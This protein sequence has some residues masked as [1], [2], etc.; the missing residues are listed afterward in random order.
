MVVER[1]ID[2]DIYTDVIQASRAAYRRVAELVAPRLTANLVAAAG[3]TISEDEWEA[4]LADVS[5]AYGDAYLDAVVAGGIAL[6]VLPPDDDLLVLLESQSESVSDLAGIIRSLLDVFLENAVIEGLPADEIRERLLS[7]PSSPLNPRKADAFAR[8]AANTAVNAGFAAAFKAAGVPAISWITQRDDRV[9]DAHV[10]VDRDVIPNGDRFM[11]DGHEARYPGD[12]ALPIGLRINCRCMLGWVDGDQVKRAVDARRADLY[13]M[14]RQLNIRGRSKMRKAQLQL[15]VIETLCLQG[16]ASGTDCPD[17]FDDMNMATLL[18]HARL[19]RIRGRY[20]MR[21]HQLLDAVKDAFTTSD[22][23]AWFQFAT[24]LDDSPVAQ[25]TALA[26]LVVDGEPVSVDVEHTADLIE[27]FSRS[28]DPVDLTLVHATPF[29]FAAVADNPLARDEM[30]QI[31]EDHLDRFTSYLADHGVAWIDVD[32]DPLEVY[33][34][35]NELDGRKVGKMI[36]AIRNGQFTPEHPAFV[37]EEGRILDGHHRWAAQAALALSGVEQTMATR[38]VNVDT[39]TLLR[40]A[41]DYAELHDIESKSHGMAAAIATFSWDPNQPRHPRGSSSGGRW[42]PYDG[43]GRP[44]RSFRPGER[45]GLYDPADIRRWH[46]ERDRI[47]S[48]QRGH[49]VVAAPTS[50]QIERYTDLHGQGLD[51]LFAEGSSPTAVIP[52]ASARRGE[53]LYDRAVVAE[54]LAR[55]VRLSAFDPR[56]LHATQ[57]GVTK[58]GVDYYMGDRYAATGRTYADQNAAGNRYPVIYRQ[59]RTGELLILS[60]HHRATAALLD[61][62]NVHGIYIDPRIRVIP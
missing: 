31:P 49:A 24:A 52:F 30:P 35:Q 17:T 11:V 51:A 42:R 8:T 46:E 28:I 13:N 21:R 6:G 15:A 34:T 54:A 12:P 53:A 37:S 60:G 16:L 5:E 50:D 3:Q 45:P 9:R 41:N 14:A 19:G 10:A 55:P 57:S 40:Y 2:A 39:N 32:V 61:G 4:V 43:A 23:P 7:A 1:H 25:I 38:Q 48:H 56:T 26:D 44:R 58:P 20:R 36:V 33:A 59:P 27:M 62:G 22:V 18:V 47:A 29:L